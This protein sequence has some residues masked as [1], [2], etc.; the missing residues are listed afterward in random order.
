MKFE[1]GQTVMTRGIQSLIEEKKF[2]MEDVIT[3]MSRHHNGDWG[4]VCEED[5][6]SNEYAVEHGE[7]LLS[8]Y[9]VNGTKIY[10][11]TEWDRSVT[12]VLLPEDY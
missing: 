9:F 10:I 4:D 3:I 2:S 11:I 12:T 8:I 1:L 5:R 7:R 6:Q